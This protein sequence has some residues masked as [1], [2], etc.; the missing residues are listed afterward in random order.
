MFIPQSNALLGQAKVESDEERGA[1][2]TLLKELNQER[3]Q[4]RAKVQ[5]QSNKVEQL[6]QALHE[7]KTT[8]KLLEQRVK[9]L[10]VRNPTQEH[11]K[12][13]SSFEGLSCFL[14]AAFMR[15]LLFSVFS[16]GRGSRLRR[17]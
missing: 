12:R 5:E 1:A 11:N 13:F 2:E 7:C 15:Q 14:P 9:Q 17:R 3:D 6:N 4:L 16:R 10:E 8:E